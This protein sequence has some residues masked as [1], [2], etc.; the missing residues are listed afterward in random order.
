MRQDKGVGVIL[1]N[2]QTIIDFYENTMSV[3]ISVDYIEDESKEDQKRSEG[4]GVMKP[5]S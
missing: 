1:P 5:Y 4:S 2:N 3:D